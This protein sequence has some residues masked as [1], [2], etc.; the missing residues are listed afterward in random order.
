MAIVCTIMISLYYYV[1]Y[2]FFDPER[3]LNEAQKAAEIIS[4]NSSIP[5]ESKEVYIQKI[6]DSTDP[7]SKLT[8]SL[9][10]NAIFSIVMGAIAALFI[11]KKEKISDVVM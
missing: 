4:E 8:G 9:Q 3:A 5:D 2:A 1:F 6:L 7:V 11:R 10:N